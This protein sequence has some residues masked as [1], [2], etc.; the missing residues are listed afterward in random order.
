MGLTF[1]VGRYASIPCDGDTAAPPMT[2]ACVISNHVSKGAFWRWARTNIGHSTTYLF[3][4]WS[5]FTTHRTATKRLIV[6]TITPGDRPLPQQWSQMLLAAMNASLTRRLP[7]ECVVVWS[8]P[9]RSFFPGMGES[10]FNTPMAAWRLTAAVLKAPLHK[11]SASDYP[12]QPSL[13]IGFLR[14]G[15]IKNIS[16][17]DSK[18]TS[19]ERARSW[20]AEDDLIA[21]LQRQPHRD[22]TFAQAFELGGMP[23][24]AQA[25]RIRQFQIIITTHGSQSVSL[26]FV[27]PCTVV[28]EIVKA[29][30]LVTLFGQLASEAGGV[31]F[32]IHNGRSMMESVALTMRLQG[33]NVA[34]QNAQRNAKDFDDLSAAFVYSTIPTL[35]DAHRQCL[36]GE[37]QGRVPFDGVPVMGR[38][39]FLDAT[40]RENNSHCFHC[41]GDSSCC[42][43]DEARYSYARGGYACKSCLS[44]FRTREVRSLLPDPLRNVSCQ[45]GWH[46]HPSSCPL[47]QKNA[48]TDVWMTGWML[49]LGSAGKRARHRLHPSSL[50][51]WD[52]MAD[53][54][55]KATNED[56]HL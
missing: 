39:R 43:S 9:S 51:T 21:M 47:Y 33:G 16:A 26:A 11:V 50:Q 5:F 38:E 31:A 56:E 30:Y 24:H 15:A 36:A 35:I 42:S 22:V 3:K 55:R 48:L 32:F 18:Q 8:A 12:G 46:R 29:G 17:S 49:S 6:D 27:R 41:R 1:D 19:Q 52:A 54:T 7:G 14:R 4:C 37:D 40:Q 2:A 25:T 34:T 53:A 44:A 45:P 13:S 20:Y 10:W 23:L 28:V